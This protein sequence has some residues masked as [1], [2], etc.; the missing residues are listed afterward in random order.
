[1]GTPRLK[2]QV[3]DLE[4]LEA[5]GKDRRGEEAREEA[6]GRG[7]D[8]GEEAREEAQDKD[9]RGEE[10][11]F[12]LQPNVALIEAKKPVK[13]HCCTRPPTGNRLL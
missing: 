10:E 7:A 13:K 9:S 2:I 8:R 5:Q 11:C 12:A 1:M 4:H 6:Q 3:I